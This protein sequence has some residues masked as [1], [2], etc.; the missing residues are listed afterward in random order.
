MDQNKIERLDAYLREDLDVTERRR[1]EKELDE[2]KELFE[3]FVENKVAMD[4]V[5][6]QIQL[7]MEEQFAD[8]EKEKHEGGKHR[9]ISPGL[10]RIAASLIF[11]VGL[12][13]VLF[14]Y[15][16]QPTYHEV[17]IEQYKLPADPGSTMGEGDQLWSEG[18][19]AFRSSDFEEAI[20]IWIQ[21]DPPRSESQYYLAHAYYNNNQPQEAAKIFR[22]IS[23]SSSIYS[24]DADWYLLLNYLSMEDEEKVKTQLQRISNAP[25][26]PYKEDAQRIA[27]QL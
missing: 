4:L 23:E 1:F 2:D 16:Y 27:S 3:M 19:E 5:D 17:A 14:Q 10:Y 25:D 12:L 20:S 9:F 18:L 15:T 7:E 22:N 8:W 21:I 13:Y 24:F 26:H 6:R 11:F